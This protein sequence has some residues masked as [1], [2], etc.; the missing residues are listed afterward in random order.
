MQ[1]NTTEPGFQATLTGQYEKLP[2][3]I[4]YT[5]LPTLE[6]ITPKMV[7]GTWL[8][9]KNLN[10]KGE[11]L[12][13]LILN[14]DGTW[15]ELENSLSQQGPAHINDK[16]QW[17][18]RKGI[19]HR[20][21]ETQERHNHHK[22]K[23]LKTRVIRLDTE[24]LWLHGNLTQTSNPTIIRFKRSS[25]EDF[26]NRTQYIQAE[27]KFIKKLAC[28]FAAALFIALT[29]ITIIGITTTPTP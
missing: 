24:N 25:K 7:A 21:D 29:A 14:N 27:H 11:S 4:H 12:Q 20:I 2:N 19:L 10:T 15:A 5:K 1:P 6:K 9:I 22:N 18:L 23:E 28:G 13:A 8:H 26:V 17:W 16:G 3:E